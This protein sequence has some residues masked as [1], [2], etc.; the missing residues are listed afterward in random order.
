M[1]V[2]FPYIKKYRWDVIWSVL[3]ILIV[4]FATLWQPHLLQVIM[5]A[6]MKNDKQT[7]W[8]NGLYLIGLAI[9]GII[10]GIVNTIYAARV[11]L[12]VAT[13]LRADEYAKIQSLAYADVEKFSPSNLVVRMTNDINQVQQIIMGFFQQVTRIPILF[14]GAVILAIMTLPELWWVIA[15]M[16]ILV[17]GVSFFSFS[18]MGKYFGRMQQLIER[19][20]TLAR[21][22]L[23]GMRVVKSFVQG[24]N[25]I[26]TFAESSDEMRDVSVKIGNLFALLMPAFFLVANLAMAGSIWLIGQDI[27]SHPS[28]L[29]AITSFINYLMQILFAIINGGFMLTFASRALVSLK[30]IQEVMD[31]KPSMTFV[32]G[33]HRDLDGAV[34]FDDVTFT[35]PG[36]EKPTISDISFKVKSGEMIG[37]VG[38]TG[39]GKTTLAQLI[40]RLF[41]P[42]TGIVK[43]GGHDVRAVTEADL[44]KTVGFV[45]QRSTLFSGTIAENLQQG[46]PNVNLDAMRW[47]ARIAQSAEFIERL[48]RTY[49]AEVEERSSNFSGGQKQR[50][51]ITRGVI[52]QPKILILDD[53]TSALD[54]HSKK[55]VQEALAH[56]LGDTTTIIIA[57]KISSIIKADR[58]L[59][60]DEGRL[61]GSGTHH[62]LVQHNDVYREIYATQKA[63]EEGV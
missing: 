51:S 63:L 4:A 9:I 25:Q 12:G 18:H 30:R 60:L 24:A 54:A 26:K 36:D 45:L 42:D 37:I 49:N 22:N 5:N 48:P 19:V 28:N 41:D 11:A 38:A 31:T 53:A 23:M 62:D 57:E 34:E 15:V 40:P 58:I 7:V 27:T 8:I 20:N 52:G 61:V 56:E 32:S 44:R 14:V 2:L 1:R 35:Y 55:L 29:A 33:P 16:M 47:A 17:F 59:V 3:A 21:E 10:G 46:N 43:V 6:I 50:L 13:D 39:S